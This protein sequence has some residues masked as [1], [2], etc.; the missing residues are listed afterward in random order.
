MHAQ[1]A[2]DSGRQ[3]ELVTRQAL[4]VDAV[5][6]FMQRAKERAGEEVRLVASQNPAIRWAERG[7]KRMGGNIQ[8]SRVEIET[9]LSGGLATELSLCV[10][11][12]FAVNSLG[13]L[14]ASQLFEA[15]T[16]ELGELGPAFEKGEFGG[17]RSWLQDKIYS[18][19][20]CMPAA[21]LV[22]SATGQEPGHAALMRHLRSKYGALYGFAGSKSAS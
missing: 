4:F 2:V 20:R 17:L 10:G 22:R 19:G 15:A 9:N 18:H 21:E 1:R 3:T 12:K 14:Y 7:A 16:E 11:A 8:S 13:N 6:R 5:A